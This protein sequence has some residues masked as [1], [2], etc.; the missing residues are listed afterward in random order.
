MP[1]TRN[2]GDVRTRAT[3]KNTVPMSQSKT[4]KPAVAMKAGPYAV[5]AFSACAAAVS[6]RASPPRCRRPRQPRLRW[7]LAPA[8]QDP[9]TCSLVQQDGRGTSPEAEGPGGGEG[10]TRRGGNGERQLKS[11]KRHPTPVNPHTPG[12]R[13][14]D[15]SAAHH[16]CGE[17]A[18][19]R[20]QAAGALAVS[21]PTAAQ[22]VWSADKA[23]RMSTATRPARPDAARVPTPG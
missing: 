3:T 6:P 5:S 14:R 22:V 21:R 13:R 20:T 17:G 10:N 8:V 4:A 19:G 23:V 1:G 12:A 9:T 18:A 15:C 2:P 11:R 7:P 16:R